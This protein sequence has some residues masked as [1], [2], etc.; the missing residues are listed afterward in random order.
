MALDSAGSMQLL[1]AQVLLDLRLQQ[2][3]ASI[4]TCSCAVHTSAWTAA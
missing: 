2:R 3:I 1:V 4:M